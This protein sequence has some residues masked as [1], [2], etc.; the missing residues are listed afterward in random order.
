M[1][2]ISWYQKSLL[3]I[4]GVAVI[5]ST[6][7]VTSRRDYAFFDPL[8]AV[9]SIVS[10]RFVETPDETAMQLGAIQGMIEALKDPYT[11][12]V[13][14]SAIREF[15]KDLTGDYVGI[16]IQIIPR[17]GWLT[18]IS[19]LEDTP[20][21]KA[22]IMPDDRIVEIEGTSTFG[23]TGD[24]CVELLAGEPG[25]PVNIVIERAGERIP[26]TIVRERIVTKTVKGFHFQS[27]GKGGADAP[28]EPGAANG[29]NGNGGKWQYLVDPGRKI[30]YMRLTQF[31]PTSAAETAAAMRAMGADKGEIGGLIL[32]LRW[33][34]GGVL[35]DAV[36]IADL[37]L[38]AGVVCTTKGRAV[39]EEIYRSQDAGTLPD[40]PVAVLVNGASASA[41]E[42]VAGA[43]QEANRAVVVGT[44]TFGKGLVQSV[45]SVPGSKGAQ[46]KITEQRY[47]LASGKLIQRTDESAEWGVDPTDGF[48]VPMT[49]EQMLDLVRVRREQEQLNR[50]QGGAADERWSD[51]DWIVE[52]LKDPQLAAALKAVQGKIDGG[53]WQPT[54]Q[55]LVKGEAIAADELK[56][57]RLARERFLRDLTRLDERIEALET[58][59]ETGQQPTPRDFWPDDVDLMGGTLQ[60]LDKDGKPVATLKITG[61]NLER[62]LI[63]ADVEKQE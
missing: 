16:G 22:G 37:F 41:S 23:K 7:A 36:D 43:L 59:A 21:F 34:P 24:E 29:P 63:D 11:E 50:A 30:A 33:S 35:T 5:G 4:L 61:N 6:V 52:R 49:D 60:V 9:K 10:Q 19:P 31:T 51:P 39:A 47:Y 17:D 28:H 13:P 8:V 45:I 32:D 42:I 57:T 62:W 12:Y 27:G 2:R 53:S 40:F 14:P 55:S 15:N 26:L 58:A 56:R 3:A 44:R 38:G 20:A 54:G 18:M 48:Y 1:N 46:L 25:K